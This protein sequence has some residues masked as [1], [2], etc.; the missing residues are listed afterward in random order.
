MKNMVLA[1]AAASAFAASAATLSESNGTTFTGLTAGDSFAAGSAAAESSKYYWYSEDSA[2]GTVTNDNTY[3]SKRAE[4]WS[5]TTALSLEAA[6][7]LFRSAEGSAT[8]YESADFTA[9]DLGDG[10]YIDTLV[11]LGVCDAAPEGGSDSDKLYVWAQEDENATNLY[12]RAG[13]YDDQG[14]FSTNDYAVSV[15]ANFDF[16]AWHR[17]T[18]QAYTAEFDNV[19][20]TKPAFRL[21]IDGA[22]ASSTDDVSVFPSMVQND[23]TICA[24]GFQGAGEI[25]DILFTTSV[26]NFAVASFNGTYYASLQDACD[27]AEAAGAGTVNVLA[28]PDTATS[29]TLST[30]GITLTGAAANFTGVTVATSGDL[31]LTSSTSDGT[32]TYTSADGVAAIKDDSVTTWYATFAEAYAA[33]KSTVHY[34]ELTVKVGSDFTPN[35]SES[36]TDFHAIAFVATTE[37]PITIVL[38]NGV[39]TM[40]ASYYYNFPSNATLVFPCSQTVIATATGSDN[41]CQI[42]GGT[43]EIP[44]GVTLTMNGYGAFDNVSGVVGAGTI[45]A[46]SNPYYFISSSKV[47]SQQWLAANT[48]TG[49]L[50]LTGSY[51]GGATDLAKFGNS[52]STIRFN[53]YTAATFGTSGSTYDMDVELVGDGLTL[54][55]DYTRTFTFTGDLSGSGALNVTAMGSSASYL[56]FSGDVSGFTGSVNLSSTTARIGFGAYNSNSGGSIAVVNGTAMTIP[57]TATWTASE[58]VVN[59]SL[60]ANGAVTLSGSLWGNAGTGVYRANTSDAA[61]TAASSWNGTYIVGWS[62]STANTA[63]YINNY[64]SHASAT[65]QIEGDSNGDFLGYPRDGDGAPTVTAKVVLN[66]NW[67]VGDGWDTKTNTFA[68]L[69]GTGNLTFTNVSGYSYKRPTTITKLENYTG[70]LGGANSQFT[71][72]KIVAAAEP[73]DGYRL[74]K[75]ASNATVANL[76]STVVEYGGSTVSGITLE[77]KSDGIYVVTDKVAEIVGGSQYETLAEA[78]AAATDGATVK[79]LD[80]VTLDARVEPNV[81]SGTSLTIDLGGY[82]LAR[83]GTS[84]NGSVFDVKSGAVTITNG[85]IDCTQDDTAIVADGVYALTVRSGASLTLDALTVTVDSQ[86]G[87][88]VYPFAGATV[89][90]LGGTYGNNTAVAYQYHVNWTGMAVNQANVATQLITI[91]GGSFY[92][93]DP[94]LGD[95]SGKVTTFLASGYVSTYDSS[96]GY[97]TVAENSGI[98]PGTMSETY[99]SAEAA[100]NAAATAT[101]AVPAAVAAAIADETAYKAMFV[102]QVTEVSGGYAVEMV[103][104]DTV[105]AEV[106]TAVDNAEV[107]VLAAAAATASG[108]NGTAQVAAK[109]GLYYVVES[110]SAVGSLAPTQ[111]VLAEGETVSL[112]IPKYANAGF[113]QIKVSV[114]PVEVPQD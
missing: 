102:A 27:A 3:S 82:T 12:V 61:V 6:N 54:N 59:G 90:I 49:T 70:T 63:F 19:A 86:A 75:L 79:L 68:C 47:A 15:A 45:V 35:I 56:T 53:G 39:Y 34:P 80:N 87:A 62:P 28:A 48:W 44:A 42:T 7:P 72:G 69:S 111:C 71:I 91:Y 13:A 77:Q 36:I 55:G 81:G 29:I 96:T 113:Y 73:T 107:T 106:E 33:A 4:D 10:I 1:L 30:A 20:T 85:V 92:K 9:V 50:E 52:G 18:V 114:V 76:A 60:T 41:V 74:V 32:T 112:S 65:I 88:C 101:V 108:E 93:V 83:T 58:L 109:P 104:K 11:K 89:T 8:A 14:A 67:T 105:A 78:V 99:A 31:A 57:S 40:A 110:A 25:D 46:P 37:D 2:S 95:D 43:L 98:E 84:G 51:T 21:Y 17:L 16:D 5:D 97:Y 66:A 24:V 100:T 26:P 64:G 103:L 23:A 94:S 38:T 22:L